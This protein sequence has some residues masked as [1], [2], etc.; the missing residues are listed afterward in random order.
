[1]QVHKSTV[2]IGEMSSS[3]H[4][5][6]HQQ[7]PFGCLWPNRNQLYCEAYV[8]E[9][10]TITPQVFRFRKAAQFLLDLLKVGCLGEISNGFF[11]ELAGDEETTQPVED[12]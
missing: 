11:R 7:T 5:I 8:H 6:C 12:L 2:S 1:M 3:P 4:G 10:H 9:R